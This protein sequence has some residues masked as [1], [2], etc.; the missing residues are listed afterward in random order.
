[1]ISNETLQV[2]AMAGTTIGVIGAMFGAF[3]Y[4]KKKGVDTD[5]LLDTSGT[6]LNA[7]QPIIGV[8]EGLL[9]GNPAINLV[10]FIDKQ[11]IKAVKGAQ[12]LNNSSQ[13]T[14]DARK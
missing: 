13:L 3:P 5:K 7:A 12:Q 11:V 6:V 9:P 2:I 10:D 1:M 14:D 4:L 8:A